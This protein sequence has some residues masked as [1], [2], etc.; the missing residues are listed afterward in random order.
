MRDELGDGV[1]GHINAAR[2]Q[3]SG[4]RGPRAVGNESTKPSDSSTLPGIV[5]SAPS[6]ILRRRGLASVGA[7]VRESER[8]QTL[9]LNTL[10]RRNCYLIFANRGSTPK[11]HRVAACPDLLSLDTG[12]DPHVTI[13]VNRGGTANANTAISEITSGVPARCLD[14]FRR[15]QSLD[16]L[17]RQ[18]F[19]DRDCLGY[20]APAITLFGRG[21]GQHLHSMAMEE[22]D[23]AIRKLEIQSRQLELRGELIVIS[24]SRR[25]RAKI[26]GLQAELS[27]IVPSKN[28]Y[29]INPNQSLLVADGHLTIGLVGSPLTNGINININGKQQCPA[30]GD[31]IRVSPRY[32]DRLRR[33][34]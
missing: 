9:S 6:R 21:S 13:T 25:Y 19:G 24:K 32:V 16:D 31:V 22:R 11:Q 4:R 17:R 5:G 18:S 12:G 14:E 3:R 28:M 26:A 27:V 7:K 15:T 1:D 10:R 2:P 30:V 34:K 23:S 8:G 29:S 20:S 33:A